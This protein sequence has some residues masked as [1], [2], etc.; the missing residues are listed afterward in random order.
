M[1]E[2]KVLRADGRGKVDKERG[3]KQRGYRERTGKG[4]GT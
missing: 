3:G 4:Q 2:R 1:G